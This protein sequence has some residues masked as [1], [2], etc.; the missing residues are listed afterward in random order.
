VHRYLSAAQLVEVAALN[1]YSLSQTQLELATGE[2]LSDHHVIMDEAMKGTVSRP[3]N[4]IPVL[5]R[6]N[7]RGSGS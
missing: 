3:A 2:I 7:G 1:S 4:Q 6:P 5:D